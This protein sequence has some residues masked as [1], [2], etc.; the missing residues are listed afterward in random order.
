MARSTR[1]ESGIQDDIVKEIKALI[2]GC[3]VSKVEFFQG[4]P[5]LIILYRDKWATLETKR[6][7]QSAHQPNQDYYVALMNEMSFS[8]FINKENKEEVLRDLQKAFGA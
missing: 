7:T 6:G 2:P 5:D 1:L 4:C 8:R 3:M